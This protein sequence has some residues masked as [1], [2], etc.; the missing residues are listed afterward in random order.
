MPPNRKG[1]GHVI[2]T[3]I[4]IDD[5]VLDDVFKAFGPQHQQEA[6]AAIARAVDRTAQQLQT[7]IVRDVGRELNLIQRA[8]KRSVRRK[9]ATYSNRQARVIV[10]DDPRR[11]HEFM[12]PSQLATQ[13]RRQGKQAARS[14]KTGSR[15]P[16][17]AK[18]RKT[19]GREAFPDA[20]VTDRFNKG[21]PRV[22]E[23]TTRARTPIKPVFGPS[24]YDIFRESRVLER[25][26]ADIEARLEREILHETTFR[27]NRIANA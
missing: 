1:T 25:T 16:L 12:T 7:E 14:R 18:V 17:R 21:R 10:F 3:G 9:R 20:F 19:A 8:I 5:D 23:R 4:T 2:G 13:Q 24:V 15:T 27:L 22:F 6:N 11:L 26:E